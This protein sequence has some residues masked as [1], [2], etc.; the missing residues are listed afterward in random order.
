MKISDFA[1]NVERLINPLEIGA[2]QFLQTFTQ[3]LP[4]A[5]QKNLVKDS[6]AKIPYMGFVVEPYA[7]FL[8]YEIKNEE[9]ANKLLPEGFKLVKTKIFEDDEPKNYCIFGCFKA[10]TSAFFGARVEFYII[11]EDQSTG[12]LSWIIVDY[13]TNTLS[14][15]NKHALRLPNSTNGVITINHSGRV[16]VD[17]VNNDGNRGLVA[18]CDITKGKMK[19]LD[20]RLW[21]EG[22]LSIGYGNELSAGDVGM[23]SLKFEPEEMAQALEIK[24]EDLNLELNKWYPGMFGDKPD[25]VLCF[26]YAQHFISDSPGRSSRLKNRDELVSSVKAIHFPNLEVF[27]TKPIKQMFLIGTGITWII[28]LI[29]MILLAIF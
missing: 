20:Q 7:F 28:I 22:N 14:Y 8:C 15:D 27:S 10:H 1:K 2:L 24:L 26:P 21:L 19:K 23:F 3:K 12:L 4:K 18:S 11:A 17:M 16:F 29:V 25:Q 5:I 9:M 13:D 6:A